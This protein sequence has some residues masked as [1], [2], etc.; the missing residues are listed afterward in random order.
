VIEFL[1]SLQVLK[2][3]TRALVVDENGEPRLWP[4]VPRNDTAGAEDHR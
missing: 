4:P 3:G 2:P 1:K